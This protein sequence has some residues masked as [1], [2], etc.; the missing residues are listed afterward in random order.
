[1]RST[2]RPIRRARTACSEQ[3][4]QPASRRDSGALPDA[5]AKPQAR[6]PHGTARLARAA[7]RLA[8]T[9]LL[10]LSHHEL[11][12]RFL[13]GTGSVVFD[14]A[15]RVAY[16]CRSPR[17]NAEVLAE[18]LA[19]NSAT[20]RSPSMRRTAR[21]RRLSHETC[22][23]RSAA[24][25]DRLCRGGG[26]W[27]NG[28]RCSS[29]C[30]PSGRR[31]SPSIA[32]RWPHSPATRSSSQRRTAPRCSP[33]RTVH[34][35]AST[36]AVSKLCAVARNES[37]RW[38]IADDRRSRRRLGT[39]HAGRSVPA[40]ARGRALVPGVA[41]GRESETADARIRA[42]RCACSSSA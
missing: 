35:A 29:G 39:L 11:S 1:M 2:S 4:G 17:T 18:A 37:S 5:G 33:C 38:P 19:T 7:G 26:R 41:V 34:F 32:R 40:A 3:L 25:R 22:C 12:G 15:C 6:A 16:A 42:G 30:R 23:S 27:R 36:P 20:S 21:R 8:V 31:S 13:E 24:Q 14:H 28:C 10:D 9:R